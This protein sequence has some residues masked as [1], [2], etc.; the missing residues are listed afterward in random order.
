MAVVMVLRLLFYILLGFRQ[1]LQYA[2]GATSLALYSAQTI[3]KVLHCL[4][5]LQKTGLLLRNLNQVTIM[6]IYSK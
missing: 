2:Y 4:G 1:E 3:T 5:P 6:G